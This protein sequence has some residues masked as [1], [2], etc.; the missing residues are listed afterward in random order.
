MAE[1]LFKA[2]DANHSDPIKDLRGCYKIGYPVVVMPDDHEWGNEERLPK[3]VI[4]KC[5]E[6][7]VEQCQQYIES[8]KDDFVYT[9]VSQKAVQ[10][11]YTVRVQNDS[12]SVSGLNNITLDK[13]ENYLL[14]W[15]CN[16]IS[17][18]FPYVQFDFRLWQ[19]VQ[20]DSFWNKENIDDYASFVL[21]SY[22]S[23]TGVGIISATVYNIPSA[24]VKS[25]IKSRECT[26]ISNIDNIYKFYVERSNLFELFKNDVKQRIEN[27]Y[28]IR[29]FYISPVNVQLIKNSGGIIT[30]TKTQLLSQIKNK[31]DY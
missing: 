2:I 11:I 15:N 18:T 14:N 25:R 22:D 28:C 16:N 12:V 30:A 8:W 29:K 26:L 27:I 9:V 4:I 6:V 24:D 20:S 13:V 10:G 19:V 3:F 21:D 1:I 7:T 23:I 31:L 17:F 5:P